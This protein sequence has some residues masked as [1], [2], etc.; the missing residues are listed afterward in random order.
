MNKR[1]LKVS[2]EK[3]ILAT[4]GRNSSRQ[5]STLLGWLAGWQRYGVNE[6]EE[7]MK[8]DDSQG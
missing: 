3:C 2:R 8:G 1:S 5:Q 6:Q 7:A 4:F